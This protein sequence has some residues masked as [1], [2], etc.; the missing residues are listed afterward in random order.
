MSGQRSTG[1]MVVTIISFGI[2]CWALYNVFTNLTTAPTITNGAVTSDPLQNAKDV[3]TTVIPFASAAVGFWF[4]SDGKSKAQDQAQAAQDQAN[5]Q[6]N[7]AARA[8]QQ[9]SAVLQA[10]PDSQALLDKA[11]Q[12]A[13]EAFS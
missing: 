9:K 3:L 7:L 12:M 4:G 13:P 8:D 6:R 5:T 1:P 10:A 11:R 2:V